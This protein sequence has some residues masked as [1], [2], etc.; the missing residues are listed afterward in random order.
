M[1]F[2]EA[3][4]LLF[5]IGT[6]VGALYKIQTIIV[7][8]LLMMPLSIAHDM[9]ANA[10]TLRYFVDLATIWVIVPLGYIGGAL[11]RDQ[12]DRLRRVAKG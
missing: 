11:L 10:S 6:I 7:L 9:L 4:V 12:L 3:S 2:F 1:S 8:A 5:V